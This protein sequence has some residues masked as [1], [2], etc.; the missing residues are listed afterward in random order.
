MNRFT[1]DDLS[2]NDFLGGRVRLWQPKAGYRAGVDPVLLAASVPAEPGQS[3]LEL[4]CGGG[5]AILCLAARIPGL[6]LIG[7]ELQ[8]AYAELA[9]RNA[10]ENGVSLGRGSG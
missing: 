10:D 7:V 2:C 9:G 3:V 8:A 5:A 6:Q 1:D 4:G